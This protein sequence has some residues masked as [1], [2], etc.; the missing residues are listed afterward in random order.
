M[1]INQKYAD[2]EKIVKEI[3]TETMGSESRLNNWGFADILQHI[4]NT[5]REISLAGRFNGWAEGVLDVNGE[6][7]VQ[8]NI[9]DSVSNELRIISSCDVALPQKITIT[10]HVGNRMNTL[11]TSNIDQLAATPGIAR[12][13]RKYV[14]KRQTGDRRIPRKLRMDT[15]TSLKAFNAILNF[16]ESETISR[17]ILYSWLGS[18]NANALE[19]FVTS[20]HKKSY[21]MIGLLSQYRDTT[22]TLDSIGDKLVTPYSVIMRIAPLEAALK[23]YG[24]KG[25]RELTFHSSVR[26][27]IEVRDESHRN[28]TKLTSFGMKL[29]KAYQTSANTPEP[30]VS[31]Q[32][33]SDAILNMLKEKPCTIHD[34]VFVNQ[35][36]NRRMIS[37][38][39]NG[40]ARKGTVSKVIIK[41]GRHRGRCEALFSLIHLSQ[42]VVDSSIVKDDE[43]IATNADPEMISSPESMLNRDRTPVGDA[44]RELYESIIGRPT[45][46]NCKRWHSGHN[47]G[48]YIGTAKCPVKGKL[49]KDSDTCNK[50]VSIVKK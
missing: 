47:V 21:S 30:I 12:A 16:A 28:R 7:M 9:A 41:N 14:R 3:L 50:F 13:S 35:T 31:R 2:V 40:L 25:Y 6:S 34:I 33:V 39:L 38:I 26:A 43:L 4:N 17:S 19:K 36:F 15:A 10:T 42:K 27:G 37:T 48:G 45:C 11:A 8:V 18:T 32:T 24:D 20:D 46:T 22:V 29:L 23:E 49:T 1:L 5:L 44:T